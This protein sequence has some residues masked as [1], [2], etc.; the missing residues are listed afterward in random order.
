[1]DECSTCKFFRPGTT[2][3]GKCVRFPMVVDKHRE[4][5]CGEYRPVAQI[6]EPARTTGT[7][8]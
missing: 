3:Y 5:A 4:D 6:K 2:A 1:M 8:R 7:K